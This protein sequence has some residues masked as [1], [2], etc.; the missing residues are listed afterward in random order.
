MPMNAEKLGFEDSRFD[1]ILG[2]AI[3]HHLNLNAALLELRRVLK[4]GGRGVFLEAQGD[5]FFVNLYRKFTPSKRTPD[6]HP[7]VNSDF[8]L[9]RTHFE[10]VEIKGFY[11][12]ALLSF[13][14]RRVWK[15]EDVFVALNKLLTGIDE[16]L[17]KIFPFL[18]R[19]CWIAVIRFEKER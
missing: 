2:T 9:I 6:E 1:V 14:L 16:Q 5:N 18:T 19:F 7:L 3:L 17:I 13:L 12:T 11:F 4:P 10:K 8:E 15:N